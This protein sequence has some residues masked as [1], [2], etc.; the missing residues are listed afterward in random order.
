VLHAAPLINKT[1]EPLDADAWIRTIK[2]KFALL[3]LPCSEA[4][5]ARLATQQLRGSARIWWDNYF[6]MLLADHVVTWYEFK[7]AFRVPA[8]YF[9]M[10]RRSTTF[11]SMR[12]IML[13]R[14]PRN[15]IASTEV[16]VP[17]SRNV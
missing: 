3:T 9:S 11:L 4:N 10:L 6:A 8:L 15:M 2:S 16:L 5:K 13:T 1:E 7:N 12:V 17:S 14:M